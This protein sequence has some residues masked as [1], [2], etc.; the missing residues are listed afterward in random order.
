VL[1]ARPATLS[2]EQIGAFR[3]IFFGTDG[4]PVGNA[5]PVQPRNDRTVRTDTGG[6]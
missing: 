4:F 1:L 5:R 6:Y 2:A 3:A